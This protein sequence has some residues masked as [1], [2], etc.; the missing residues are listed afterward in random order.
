MWNKGRYGICGT[1]LTMSELE[2]V[3]SHPDQKLQSKA[4]DIILEPECSHLA[5]D[6]SGN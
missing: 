3:G 4:G 2:R 5:K 6:R 1:A